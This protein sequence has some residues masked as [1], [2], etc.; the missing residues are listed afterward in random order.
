M[1]EIERAIQITNLL[2]SAVP[3]IASLITLIRNKD[4]SIN[5]LAILD[6]ADEQFDANLKTVSDYLK[7]HPAK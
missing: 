4:G 7:L 2:N 5:V 3:G 6:Q 1:N